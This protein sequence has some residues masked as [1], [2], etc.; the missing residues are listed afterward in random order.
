V[1]AVPV[2]YAL[3]CYQ[4]GVT[5]AEVGDAVARLRP[6]ACVL[7]LDD[8]M[9]LFLIDAPDAATALTLAGEAAITVDRLTRCRLLGW[10]P[11]R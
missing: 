2:V 6:A 3:E 8:D 1:I 5:E 10:S 7:F 9:I 11:S 4:P